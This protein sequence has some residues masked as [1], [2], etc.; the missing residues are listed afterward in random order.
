MNYAGTINSQTVAERIS[1]ALRS[2][3]SG[4]AAPGKQVSKMTGKCPRT[5]RNIMDGSNAPSAST[6]IELMRDFDEV[7]VEVLRLSNRMSD[8]PSG[9]IHQRIEQAINI[10]N[11]GEHGQ[12]VSDRNTPMGKGT[13][14]PS[15]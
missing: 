12:V 4:W 7:Y 15:G 8:E 13:D 3:V 9:S 1:L 11:G 14:S 10:L 6:L 2:T 5:I